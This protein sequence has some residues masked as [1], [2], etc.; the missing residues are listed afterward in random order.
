MGFHE[1]GRYGFWILFPP[2]HLSNINYSYIY[3]NILKE[4]SPA[5]FFKWFVLI[6][7]YQDHENIISM[8]QW[9]QCFQ[10]QSRYQ[11]IVTGLLVWSHFLQPVCCHKI[12]F[13]L[14]CFSLYTA[15]YFW[16]NHNYGEPGALW[17]W[18][19][20]WYSWCDCWMQCHPTCMMKKLSSVFV[21]TIKHLGMTLPVL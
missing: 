1:Y 14:V 5:V 16:R 13:L 17:T 6:W 9:F 4:M 11:N 2:F 12:Y 20:S 15:L 8:S 18:L 3:T 19:V 21:L 7:M 10:T